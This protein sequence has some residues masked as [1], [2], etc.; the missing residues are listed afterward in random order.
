MITGK[1]AIIIAIIVWII[2]A[3]LFLLFCV[4]IFSVNSEEN[5]LFNDKEQEEYLKIWNEAQKLKLDKRNRRNNEREKN[6]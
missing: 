5:E 1:V 6:N 4:A 2:L 3:P